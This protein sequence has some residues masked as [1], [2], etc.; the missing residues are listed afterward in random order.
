MGDTDQTGVVVRLCI[1]CQGSSRQTLRALQAEIDR[2]GLPVPV[3]VR[4]QDCMN[5]CDEPVAVAIQGAAR[6]SY[7]FAGLS[8]VQDASEIAATIAAYLD[9]PGGWIEDAQR[10]GRLRFCLKG[11]IPALDS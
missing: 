10:C 2:A 6:A 1:S 5:L 7:L 3:R 11:R 4:A 8:P 9:S